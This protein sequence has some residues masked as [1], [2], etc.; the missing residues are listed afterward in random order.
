MVH[1]LFNRTWLLPGSLVIT[2]VTPSAVLSI[3]YNRR[4]MTKYVGENLIVYI[5]VP[6]IQ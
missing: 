1:L 3:S 2:K 4:Y 5:S 6:H